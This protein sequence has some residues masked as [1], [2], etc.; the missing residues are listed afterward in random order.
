MAA[1]V[2][3]VR[4]GPRLNHWYCPTPTGLAIQALLRQCQL[5]GQ[6]G[7][8]VGHPGC[9]KTAAL[10]DF[11][12]RNHGALY[13]R[14]GITLAE[15]RALLVGLCKCAGHHWIESVQSARERLEQLRERVG[16]GKGHVIV[17]DEA[18]YLTNDGLHLARDLYDEGFGGIVLAG[19]MELMT[20]LER[21]PRGKSSGFAHLMGRVG[22]VQRYAAPADD[23]I[24]MLAEP[25]P[26][27]AGAKP[28]FAK[29]AR[30]WN[31]HRA[32]KL[33]Q[34]AARTAGAETL[35]AK[36]LRDAAELLNIDLHG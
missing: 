2:T 11:C 8:L 22:P 1:T 33:V 12:E 30:R 6:L 28:L 14:A 4:E 3:L 34:M 31:L 27:T 35:D 21:K 24:D 18:Q 25:Y 36:M 32:A 7:L 16:A 5:E 9:G 20:R 23:D 26:L 29:V 17:I 13:L 15:A 19:N 10:V